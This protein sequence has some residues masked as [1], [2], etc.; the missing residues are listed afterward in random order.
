LAASVDFSM[1]ITVKPALRVLFAIWLMTLLGASPSAAQSDL[2]RARTL[3]NGGEFDAA[4]VAATAAG[5]KPSIAPSAALI[6]A[7][8][9]LEKF[10]KLGDAE[11]LVTA[12]AGLV[13]L[14][15]RELAPQEVIE[16]QV[17]IAT[18]L[19]LENQL[20]SAVDI[21]SSV[22]PSARDRL[23]EPDLEKLLEWLGTSMS[24]LA[25]T[26]TG[27]PRKQAYQKL[28]AQVRLELERNPLSRSALYWTAVSERGAGD[29]ESAW[30]AAVAAW[31]R[32]GGDPEREQLRTDVE[33]FVTQTLIPERAQARTG[34]R[35]DAKTT[36][37]EVAVLT[38][39][40]RTITGRWSGEE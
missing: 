5:R 25:E 8:S 1:A 39:E 31:V 22:M 24:R 36:I 4:I 35:L 9:Q 33:R 27:E 10:R 32:I 3:Y 37:G 2:A 38:E 12:R 7:R 17:G 30:A 28:R 16:W 18:V 26:L 34:Q 11:A 13:S 21:F 29:L 6:I 19:F 23:S 15:P 20:G 14:N 40:W